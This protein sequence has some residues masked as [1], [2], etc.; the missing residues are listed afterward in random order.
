MFSQNYFIFPDSIILLTIPVLN[1]KAY[2]LKQTNKE[3]NNGLSEKSS[4]KQRKQTNKKS[5][6]YPKEIN[7]MKIYTLWILISNKA[8][9]TSLHK[10]MPY[11]CLWRNPKKLVLE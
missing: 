8:V 7:E 9:K 3:T 2:A 6:C 5:K 4:K 11:Y 10:V 1:Y